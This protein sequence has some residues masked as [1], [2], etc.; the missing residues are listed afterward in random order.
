MAQVEFKYTGISIVI[1]FKENEI[2]KNIIEEFVQKARIVKK[3]NIY[4][5]YD[6][7]ADIKTKENLPFLEVLIQWIKIKKR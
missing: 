1:K 7:K 2:M 4:F 6:G 3:N 5:L